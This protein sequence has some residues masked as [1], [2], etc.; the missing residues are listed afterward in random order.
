MAEDLWVWVTRYP[1]GSV[2]T[3]SAWVP[4][5]KQHAVLVARDENIAK[6]LFGPLAQSH[7]QASG[8]EV[9]LRRYRMVEDIGRAKA[10]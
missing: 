3:I 7:G 9:W 5:L 2:G 6:I 1:D 10:N 4:S 8:Q